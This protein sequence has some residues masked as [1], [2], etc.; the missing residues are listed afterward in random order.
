LASTEKVSSSP[1]TGAAP[2]WVFVYFVQQKQPDKALAR[3]QAQIQRSPRSSSLQFLAARLLADK[4]DWKGAEAAAQKSVEL[5]ENIQAFLLLGQVQTVQGD[6][7]KAIAS[8]ERSIKENP[9]D[10][11][12]Y[13]LAATLEEKRGNWQRA[14]ELYLK[15][16]QVKPEFPLA[17]NNLAYLLLEHG[18]NPDVALSYA[19]VARRGLQEEPF[20]ADTLGWAYYRKGSYG[21][22]ADMFHEALKKQPDNPS[23]H[24]H[25][26]L[27]YSKNNNPAGAKEHLEKALQIKPDSP[28]AEEIRKTIAQLGK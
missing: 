6:P 2:G 10:V 26:G 7:A 16:L 3:V 8:Y 27:A 22:A 11:R 18:G 19:Q 12:G 14:Q 5:D 17:A 1:Q 13:I 4:R 15:A 23:Y 25:L 20:T 24:F 9:Q 28:Q 21:L